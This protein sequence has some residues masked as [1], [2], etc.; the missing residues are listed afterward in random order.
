MHQPHLVY[1]INTGFTPEIEYDRNGNLNW[2][3]I[4]E[5]QCLNEERNNLIIK[6]IQKFKDRTFLV[7]TKRVEGANILFK[8]LKDMNEHVDTYIESQTEFDKNCRILIGTTSKVGVGFDHD[9][10]D[11]LI[12]ASDLEEY[13]IQ[14]LGRVFRRHDTIPIVF[15]LVDNNPVLKRHFATRKSTY[16]EAGG[17]ISNFTIE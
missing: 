9:K 11:A 15:D 10:L 1:K 3:K 14:Y 5:A 8:K 2:G 13:F 7:L 17:R 12:L 16:M 4:I 6:I